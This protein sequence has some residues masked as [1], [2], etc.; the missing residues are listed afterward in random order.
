[1]LTNLYLHTKSKRVCI[2]ERS[3]PASLPL[4]GQVTKNTTVKWTYGQ[5]HSPQSI[6]LQKTK[7]QHKVHVLTVFSC[8]TVTESF[9]L[10][11]GAVVAAGW[12]KIKPWWL[13]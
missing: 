9:W 13:K 10:D 7:Q 6:H 5:K 4:K 12:E 8:L 2:K 11:G 3:T 1:M